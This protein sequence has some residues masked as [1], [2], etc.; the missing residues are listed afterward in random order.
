MTHLS[1]VPYGKRVLIKGEVHIHV[2]MDRKSPFVR[3]TFNT[4]DNAIYEWPHSEQVEVIE[5]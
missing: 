5:C 1:S 2:R 4:K 3:F